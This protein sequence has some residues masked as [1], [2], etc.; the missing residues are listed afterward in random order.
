MVRRKSIY[1]KSIIKIEKSVYTV[2]NFSISHELETPRGC[3]KHDL[4]EK[5]GRKYIFIL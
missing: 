2:I 4:K 1:V 3:I 5:E